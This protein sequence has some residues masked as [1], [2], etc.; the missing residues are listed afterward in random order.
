MSLSS[1]SKTHEDSHRLG[2]LLVT[3]NTISKAQLRS[4]L[5]YQKAHPHLQLGQILSSRFGTSQESLVKSLH[6]QQQLRTTAMLL[7]LFAAPW[8]AAWGDAVSDNPSV[9]QHWAAS[10]QSS[11]CML[12]RPM[13]TE[14]GQGSAVT[15]DIPAKSVNN[16]LDLIAQRG[17][18]KW[19]E[20]STGPDTPHRYHISLSP[21]AVGLGW[22]F[23]F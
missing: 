12:Q 10:C 8:Q 17:E 21:T 3:N 2:T 9:P 4:A 14:M 6:W 19:M 5:A 18:L 22:T 20:F 11:L 13:T 7:S 15:L 23:K 16:L 1:R